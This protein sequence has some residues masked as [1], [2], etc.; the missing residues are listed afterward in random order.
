MKII[1]VADVHLGATNKRLSVELAKQ[2]KIENATRLQAVFSNAKDINAQAILISGD[3]FHSKSPTNQLVK[4]FLDLVKTYTLPVFYVKGNHDEDFLF[5]DKLLPKNLIIFNEQ[6]TS[7]NLDDQVIVSGQSGTDVHIPELEKDKY[8]IV[9]LHG[10]IH[11]KG[12][13]Y[14]DISKLKNKH[15]DYL[16][17]GHI[18]SFEEGSLDKRGKYVYSGCLTANGFDELGSKGFVVLDTEENKTQFIKIVGREFVIKEV[19]ITGFKN[20][21][22]L[23]IK[24]VKQLNY[25]QSDIV[26]VILTGYY[27]EE[28]EKFIPLLEKNIGLNF[29]YFEIVDKTKIKI[30][31]EK[32]KQEVLSFKAEF[33][34]LVSE[35]ENLSEEDKSMIC[36]IGINAL[37]GDDV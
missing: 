5:A 9:L 22:D 32:L 37:R 29:A 27:T 21:D 15:I 19:D 20:Y 36:E 11:S 13:D 10:D 28:Q 3:L 7:Y 1:H 4:F 23:E 24:V 2:I 8:N 16:S 17:L 12:N 18:H 25:L 6:F 14:L 31:T 30:D 33:L 34:K 26:R 35:D